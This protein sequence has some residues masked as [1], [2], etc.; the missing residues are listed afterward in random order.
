M[1]KKAMKTIRKLLESCRQYYQ[2]KVFRKDC[3]A[4]AGGTAI[5]WFGGGERLKT[6]DD[7]RAGEGD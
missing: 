7:L 4:N 6:V 2:V 3:K 5:D 1:L